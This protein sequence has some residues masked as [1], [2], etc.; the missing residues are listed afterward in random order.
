MDNVY[1]L[2]NAKQRTSKVLGWRHLGRKFGFNKKTL[3]NL[4]SPQGEIVSP[5]EA[6][7]RRLGGSMPWLSMADFIWALHGIGR[8]DA[9]A[10][11]DDYLPGKHHCKEHTWSTSV[12]S[13]WYKLI[14]CCRT[15]GNLLVGNTSTNLFSILCSNY[16]RRL[17]TTLR[18]FAWLPST[19]C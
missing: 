17:F 10:V 7:I 14:I 9:L 18:V 8:N 3:D 2:L 12:G 6:L 15:T 13:I 5:T 4:S 16:K 1:E 11:L 19:F